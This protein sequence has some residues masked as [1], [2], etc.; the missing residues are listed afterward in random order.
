MSFLGVTEL[1]GVSLESQRSL[2]E[3]PLVSMRVRSS[4]MMVCP[5]RSQVP[6]RGKAGTNTFGKRVFAGVAALRTLR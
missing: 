1:V 2:S 4:Q 6:V 5:N 3:G